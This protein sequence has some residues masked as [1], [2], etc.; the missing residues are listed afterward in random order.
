MRTNRVALP[1]PSH[2]ARTAAVASAAATATALVIGAL[3]GLQLVACTPTAPGSATGTTVG[4]TRAPLSTYASIASLRDALVAQGFTCDLAYAGL[5]D[6]VAEQEVSLCTIEGEQAFLYIW[7]DADALRAFVASP[8]A[9]SG[10][11]AA[12][13]NWH[14]VVATRATATRLASAIG[15]EVP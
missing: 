11:V 15:G 12:G 6:D 3:A 10:Q 2:Q 1:T 14:I 4:G 13:R 7:F 9:R 5:R 8:E